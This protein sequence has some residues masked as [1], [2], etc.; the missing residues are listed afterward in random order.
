MAKILNLEEKFTPPLKHFSNEE[1]GLKK[2]IDL[3]THYIKNVIIFILLVFGNQYLTNNLLVVF[4]LQVLYSLWMFF[5]LL[6]IKSYNIGFAFQEIFYNFYIM[7][8]I[9]YYY[10]FTDLREFVVVVHY[11]F[12]FSLSLFFVFFELVFVFVIRPLRMLI[13]RPVPE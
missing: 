8:L 9:Y 10:N 5:S 2:T 13:G 12:G 4:Q 7:C 3:T 1:L 11:F 6:K